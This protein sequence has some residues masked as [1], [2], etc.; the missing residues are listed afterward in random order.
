MTDLAV[1]ATTPPVTVALTATADWLQP[2][3]ASKATTLARYY[4]WAILQY[5]LDREQICGVDPVATAG[6]FTVDN[7]I[8][9]AAPDIGQV[10][11]YRQ[12][13]DDLDLLCANRWAAAP[14]EM[15]TTP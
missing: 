7:Y 10:I 4:V 2:E 14:I 1:P 6:E 12:L 3:M 15:E 5:R 11:N 9:R 8:D 13:A